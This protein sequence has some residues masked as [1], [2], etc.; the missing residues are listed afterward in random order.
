[1]I[2]DDNILEYY[3]T[4]G[5]SI[6]VSSLPSQVD[7]GSVQQATVSISDDDSKL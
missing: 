4:F 3:E 1:M 2:T 7:V 6:N 5:L